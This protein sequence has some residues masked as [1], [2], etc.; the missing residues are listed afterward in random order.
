MTAN[1]IKSCITG[2]LLLCIL[3]GIRAQPAS[4]TWKEDAL[5]FQKK[6][7]KQYKSPRKSPLKTSDR[8]TFSRLNFYAPNPDFCVTARLARTPDAQAFEVPT[9]SGKK[10]TY[11]S[12]GILHFEISGQELSIPV[13]QNVKHIDH[14]KYGK[15]LFLPFT[16]LT[17]GDENYG[18]GRYMDLEI[19]EGDEILLD[20]NQCYNPYCAYATGWNCPIPPQENFLNIRI[21]AGTKPGFFNKKGKLVDH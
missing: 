4:P 9:S 18:G 17:S 7:N 20:F 21:E 16:D 12:Y 19:P 2:L 11:K 14:P 8:R 15:F 13:Y 10:K 5:S 1:M 6:Q 3:S